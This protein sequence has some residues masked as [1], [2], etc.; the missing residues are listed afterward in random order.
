[1]NAAPG[2][3]APRLIEIKAFACPAPPP[4]TARPGGG[5]RI[6]YRPGDERAPVLRSGAVR[7]EKRSERA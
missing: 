7:E 5:V 6:G 1:M 4:G 2:G 3:C